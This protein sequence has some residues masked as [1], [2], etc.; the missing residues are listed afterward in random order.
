MKLKWPSC[1]MLLFVSEDLFFCVLQITS[2]APPRTNVVTTT[3]RNSKQFS[4]FC[5]TWATFHRKFIRWWMLHYTTQHFVQYLQVQFFD[6]VRV[7]HF[8]PSLL[9]AACRFTVNRQFLQLIVLGSARPTSLLLS[10]SHIPFIVE[11]G[12]ETFIICS[13]PPQIRRQKKKKRRSQVDAA[14]AAA[15]TIKGRK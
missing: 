10:S 7:F 15:A 4:R 12:E 11:R 13:V 2:S 9:P 3:T 8:P 1:T 6:C 14:A 5:Q